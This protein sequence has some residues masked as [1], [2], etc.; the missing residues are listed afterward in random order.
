MFFHYHPYEP[1]LNKNTKFLEPAVGS[2][3]FYF[4]MLE[5][6]LNKGFSLEYI[7]ENMIYAYDIDKNALNILIKKLK[8]GFHIEIN[9][10]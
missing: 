10:F 1:F 7:V 8:N 4:A 5:E 3:S 2:G 6:L 9:I